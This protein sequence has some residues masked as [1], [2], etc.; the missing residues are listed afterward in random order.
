M[1]T[2]VKFGALVNPTSRRNLRRPQDISNLVAKGA[3]IETPASLEE[4]PAAINRLTAAKLDVLAIS[5]GD[6][7]V[8]RALTHILANGTSEN[9]PALCLTPDGTT[10]MTAA[11]VG[12][13]SGINTLSRAYELAKSGKGRL[14]TR[15]TIRLEGVTDR[16]GST[17]PQ[18][19]MFFGAIGI[20]RAIAFCRTHLHRR[21][22]VGGAA[23]WLT[24]TPLLLK[25]I[26]SSNED[27][28]LAGSAMTLNTVDKNGIGHVLDGSYSILMASTLERLALG[29]RPFWG[30]G[31]GLPMT[32][33]KAPPP[34]LLANIGPLLFGRA[35]RPKEPGYTSL[36]NDF[37]EI[38]YTGQVTLDGELYDAE[39]AQPIRLSAGGEVRFLVP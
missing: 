4:V 22:I 5:G 19:G 33:V 28:V 18:I 8:L 25:N 36:K 32:A 7:T 35:K 39:A 26:L 37:Y 2:S 29:A 30:E 13:P 24:L 12:M 15:Q 34:K 14:I 21:G 17:A 10:N 3:I 38:F 31:S 9:Q 1:S 11:D 27:G 16:M 20:C 6:G 23:S